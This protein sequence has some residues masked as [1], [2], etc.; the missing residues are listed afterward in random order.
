ML[1]LSGILI[2]EDSLDRMNIELES[3]GTLK[4]KLQSKKV[5]TKNTSS[6]HKR[7]ATIKLS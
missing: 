6:F 5:I 4:N 3:L 2:E 7:T 1:N